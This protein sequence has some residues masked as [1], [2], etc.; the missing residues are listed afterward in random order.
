MEIILTYPPLPTEAGP[1]PPAIIGRRHVIG[2]TT[3]A[4]P[5]GVA[6]GTV[7]NPHVVL[8]DRPEIATQV[9]A[10]RPSVTRNADNIYVMITLCI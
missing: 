10:F 7:V 3:T 6:Q 2:I 1:V 9:V 4:I 8:D 5:T